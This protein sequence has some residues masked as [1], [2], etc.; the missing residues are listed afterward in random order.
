MKKALLRKIIATTAKESLF[1]LYITNYRLRVTL[2]ETHLAYKQRKMMLY[3]HTMSSQ[4]HNLGATT[5]SMSHHMAVF[6]SRTMLVCY[7]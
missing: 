5:G 3:N 6:V 2:G 7:M 1:C 4:C